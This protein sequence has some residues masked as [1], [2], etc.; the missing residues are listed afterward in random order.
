MAV[1]A[2]HSSL[3]FLASGSLGESIIPAINKLQDVFSQ[4][5]GRTECVAPTPMPSSLL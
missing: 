4:V 3:A 1:Q 5:R 2:S